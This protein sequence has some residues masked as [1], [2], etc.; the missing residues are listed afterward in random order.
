MGFLECQI[1]DT[2]NNSV[3]LRD[4]R[5]RSGLLGQPLLR[6]RGQG[7]LKTCQPQPVKSSK[8]G[9]TPATSGATVSPLPGEMDSHSTN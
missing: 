4:G 7:T 3:A 6:W 8:I 2:S 9:L 1:R 5:R